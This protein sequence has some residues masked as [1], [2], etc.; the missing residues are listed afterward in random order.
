MFI[1]I[2]I[3]QIDHLRNELHHSIEAETGTSEDYAL[4]D[5][6][7]LPQELNGRVVKTNVDPGNGGTGTASALAASLAIMLAVMMAMLF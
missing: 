5:N 6:H 3:H 1:S 2:F 7:R 4:V